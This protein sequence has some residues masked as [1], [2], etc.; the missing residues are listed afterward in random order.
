MPLT[1]QDFISKWKR[2]LSDEVILERLLKLSL[3]S[4]KDDGGRKMKKKPSKKHTVAAFAVIVFILTMMFFF[5]TSCAPAAGSG[6]SGAPVPTYEPTHAPGLEPEWTDEPVPSDPPLTS[7]S[8]ALDALESTTAGEQI[9]RSG[10]LDPGLIRVGMLEFQYPLELPV[11]SSETVILYA[12]LPAQL[13]SANLD[14]FSRVTVSSDSPGVVDGLYA[15]KKI[16]LLYET[17]RAEIRSTSFTIQPLQADEPKVVEVSAPNVATSWKWIVQAPEYPG[18]QV[19]V[20]SVYLG[21][22]TE[23]SWVGSIKINVVALTDTPF[24]TPTNTPVPP[25]PTL[26]P[27]PSPTST[28]LPFMKRLGQQVVEGISLEVCLGIPAGIL[29]LF[30][31]WDQLK[32]RR[33]KKR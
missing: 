29:A 19:L 12:Y 5:I 28:P 1:P 15:Y 3:E 22:S 24:P 31:L 10:Q 13:A 25:T 2:D 21:N 9:V 23:P 30:S 8:P 14:S 6:G 7:A 18:E 33:L 11:R 17:M 26:T 20:V 32:R 16:S 4:A 27:L